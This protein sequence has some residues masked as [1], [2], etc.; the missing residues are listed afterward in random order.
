[1][2]PKKLFSSLILQLPFVMLIAQSYYQL[3]GTRA[4]HISDRWYVLGYDQSRMSS[5]RNI[6]RRDL[7]LGAE[8]LEDSIS[9]IDLLDRQYVLKNNTE[10]WQK[11]DFGI[12]QSSMQDKKIYVDSTG[13]FF[14][15]ESENKK[16][17]D[18][19]VEEE[20]GVFGIL[21]NNR[22]NFYEVNKENFTLRAN[23]VLNIQFGKDGDQTIVRN[24]RGAEV[25]GTIDNK[26][27]Y[28]TRVVDNQR[29]FAEYTDS[30]ISKYKAVPGHGTYK[31]FESS[32]LDDFVGYDYFDA[33]GYVGLDVSKSVAFEL[34]HGQHMIGNG[35]R[36]LLLSNSGDNYFYLKLNTRIWK[37]QYQ[38]IW[39]ELNSIS[40]RT[41]QGDRLLSKKFMASHY[42][43]YKPTAKFEIGLFETVI[44]DRENQYELQYLNPII[45]YRVVESGLG[46]P[47]N[48]LL[49]LN[50]SYTFGGHFQA[51]GQLVMDEFNLT[52]LRNGS[53]WWAN[54]VGYQ[55]GLKYY[56]ALDIDHLDLQLEYNTVRPY[57]YSHSRPLSVLPEYSKASYSHH[58]QPLAH[59][60]GANFR[61][62][63]GSAKYQWNEKLFFQGRAMIT[64]YGEDGVGN[65]FGNNILL[66]TFEDIIDNTFG[67]ETGQGLKTDILLLSLNTSYQFMYNYYLDLDVLY[68][69]SNSELA[70]RNIDTKYI[71]LGLRV[72]MGRENIDY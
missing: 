55:L 52:E 49:G 5:I 13:T 2:D 36:S 22:A 68:R 33:E 56:N 48:V 62:I 71:G 11:T 44:F 63:V 59:P 57:T 60:L 31:D 37:L 67:N 45:L 47:D 70:S 53:G 27:Y 16:E 25:R 8:N 12:S 42:L 1:M 4:E 41:L 38:N 34:G 20:N 19:V 3:P 58:S 35:I 72:N 6:D 14:Y 50:M 17:E 7:L 9:S 54:K 10:F 23:P 18:L 29:S 24:T 21:Y 28:Y 65:N 69:S 30:T 51:Y 64:Q 15:Y 46:S 32:V 66:L 43:S 40:F 39:A 61:E 26:I